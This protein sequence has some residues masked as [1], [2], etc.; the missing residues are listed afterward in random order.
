MMWPFTIFPVAFSLIPFFLVFL[1]LYLLVHWLGRREQ[2][3]LCMYGL[4]AAVV[5][6]PFDL[7]SYKALMAIIRQGLNAVLLAFFTLPAWGMFILSTF[8]FLKS[9]ASK[10][11][12][13]CWLAA[14]ALYLFNAAVYTQFA[15]WVM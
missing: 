2:R 11:Y 10:R 8:S 14:T 15:L 3:A 12:A 7:L 13:A 4:F 5:T 1:F 9:R 6:A